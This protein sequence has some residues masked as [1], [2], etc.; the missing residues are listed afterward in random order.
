MAYQVH[1][2]R[3]SITS[4]G[5]LSMSSG[6]DGKSL[7]IEG[8]LGGVEHTID[9]AKYIR[10]E[11]QSMAQMDEHVPFR[12][13]GDSSMNGYVKVLGASLDIAKY[14]LGSISYSVSMEYIGKE[15]DVLF[16]SR[17]TGALLENDFVTSTTTEQFHAAP[18]NNFGYLH[19][20]LP[21]RNA[22]TA[23]NLT[24][25]SATDTTTLYI[26]QSQTLRDNNA[27]YN[28]DVDDYYKGACEIR[29]GN[30]MERVSINSSDVVTKSIKCGKNAGD[31]TV[32]DTL[33]VDNGLVKMVLG[34]STSS[35]KFSTYIWD[36]NQ[37]ATEVE[38]TLSEG[39]PATSSQHGNLFLGWHR[40]QI[41]VNR[42]ELVVVRC[43]TYKDAST[44]GKRLVVDFSLRR[45]AHHIG[46]ITNY[47][48]A[49]TFINIAPDTVPGTT[50]N[51]TDIAKGYIKDGTTSPEDGNFWFIGALKSMNTTS[52][53]T[54]R[55]MVQS[56]TA[57]SIFGFCIGYELIDP[58][59]SA[60][61][62]HNDIDSVYKQ[63]IDNVNEF[64]KLVKA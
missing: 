18:G 27:V 42:P 62:A 30:H 17:L 37:Y 48:T 31:W 33:E 32:G 52:A 14:L 21:G 54:N 19:T 2:G 15:G 40:V 55:G 23:S 10:D 5:S 36:V 25:D 45:G 41:L 49:G 44:R 7:D 38:W 22:R 34:T 24:T 35:A 50:P 57:G 3:L 11:L 39:A 63:Y 61:L 8:K 28:L 16:E 12:Y 43:T 13:D 58:D 4:P 29:M 64:Q 56:A 1:I 9:H 59:T 6:L 47:Y 51:T 46:V 20:S 26:N 60:A 53:I